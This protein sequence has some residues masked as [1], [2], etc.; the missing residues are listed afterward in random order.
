MRKL[1]LAAA[2]LC[3]GCGGV[4]PITE[5]EAVGILAALTELLFEV[6][7]YDEGDTESVSCPSGGSVTVEVLRQAEG[8]WG[9]QKVHSFRPVGCAVTSAGTPFTVDG[10]PDLLWQSGFEYIEI[11]GGFIW[12]RDSEGGS[13]CEVSLVHEWGTLVGSLCD[14]DVTIGLGQLFDEDE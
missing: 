4:E 7:V 11:N 13:R 3:A 9:Q 2:V 14:L 10:D 1:I 8:F 12:D 6:D 5:E